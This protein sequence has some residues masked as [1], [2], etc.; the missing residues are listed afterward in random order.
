[1]TYEDRLGATNPS[2]TLGGWNSE[3]VGSEDLESLGRRQP[4]AEL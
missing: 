2:D 3:N 4:R 1:M